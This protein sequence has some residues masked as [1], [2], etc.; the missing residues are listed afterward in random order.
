MRNM[1]QKKPEP[2]LSRLR[3]SSNSMRKLLAVDRS[4][5]AAGRA[6]DCAVH[7]G[8]DG[9]TCS[10]RA[11]DGDFGARAG[12]F[13]F[14]TGYGDASAFGLVNFVG[15]GRAHDER[16]GTSKNQSLHHYFPPWTF[17]PLH[18]AA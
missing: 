16:K 3:Q 15:E 4:G 11:L 9:V 2:G 13:V 17:S 5:F 8:L 1:R 6:G 14:L 10:W 7:A 18:K 12:E